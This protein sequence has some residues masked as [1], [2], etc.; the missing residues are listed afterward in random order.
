V[1]RRSKGDAGAPV[2]DAVSVQVCN[3]NAQLVHE[4]LQGA[5]LA[6][7]ASNSEKAGNTH[8]HDCL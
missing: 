6:A 1:Q 4:I 8:L 5:R 2:H 7:G 3:A